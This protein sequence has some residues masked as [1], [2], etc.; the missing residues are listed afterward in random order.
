MTPTPKLRF[1]E[2]TVPMHPFYKTVDG[3]GNITQA[4]QTFRILQ[5][6]W[7]EKQWAHDDW[8][9]VGGEWRDVQLE[10]E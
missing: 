9:T 5:Q 1:I 4:T 8:I 2:R 10:K 3:L 6:W 7:E